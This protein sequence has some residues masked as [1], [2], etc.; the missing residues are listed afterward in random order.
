MLESRLLRRARSRAMV[1]ALMVGGV[2]WLQA[3]SSASALPQVVAQVVTPTPFRFLTPTPITSTK[4]TTGVTV[5]SVTTTPAPAPR[6][7]GFPMELAF[8]TLAGGAAAISGGVF[9]LRRKLAR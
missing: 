1:A 8:P 6:A 5:P 7:G 2:V 9:L 3:A 4:T